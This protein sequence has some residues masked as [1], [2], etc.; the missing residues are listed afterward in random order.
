VAIA[1]AFVA[2]LSLAGCGADQVESNAR[3][4]A[5]RNLQQNVT[6]ATACL[7]SI[8]HDLDTAQE[9]PELAHVLSECAGTTFLNH[10]DD[11]IRSTDP[12]ASKR[13]TIA[14]TARETGDRELAL[15][16]STSGAGLS[17]AGVSRAR[18][19]ITSCWQVTVDLK[20]HT[21]G[22]PTGTSC[23]KSV[24]ARENPSE[25]VPFDDLNVPA[26]G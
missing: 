8:A 9:A 5:Y 15:T 20:T 11:A 21:L 6:T 3:D 1:T 26:P 2:G 14:V 25:Q 7:Q 24:I 22:E 19:L 4:T 17:E 16:L 10:D 18:A 23:N 12:L 13:G